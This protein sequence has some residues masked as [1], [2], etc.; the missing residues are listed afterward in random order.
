[1]VS[2]IQSAFSEAAI[3]ESNGFYRYAFVSRRFRLLPVDDRECALTSWEMVLVNLLLIPVS[4]LPTLTGMTRG[5]IM[6]ATALGIVY[7]GTPYTV[8]ANPNQAHGRPSLTHVFSL[9]T[10]AIGGNDCLSKGI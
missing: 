10:A 1:M 2:R 6:P 8:G 9:R 5:F 4:L 7:C 3:I